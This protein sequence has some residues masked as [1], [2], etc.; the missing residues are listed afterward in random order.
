[1]KVQLVAHPRE[2]S[3]AFDTAEYISQIAGKMK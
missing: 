1:M 2:T 3:I